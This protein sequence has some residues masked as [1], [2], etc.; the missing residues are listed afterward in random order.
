MAYPEKNFYKDDFGKD[1]FVKIKFY[2]KKLNLN[3]SCVLNINF[4][5][6]L[7]IF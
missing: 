1:S 4:V 7:V 5:I 6:A 2:Q 3:R